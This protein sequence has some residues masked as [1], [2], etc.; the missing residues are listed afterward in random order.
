MGC[1]VQVAEAAAEDFSGSS[2]LAGQ[3]EAA[4]HAALCGHLQKILPVC[5]TRADVLWA[6]TRSWLELQLDSMLNHNQETGLTDGLR[7]GLDAAHAV[8]RS[9]PEQPVRIVMD[10]LANFWPPTRC[11]V[12]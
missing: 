3:F 8:K 11:V 10:D 9:N 7:A 2:E 6:Y 5:Q 1:V 4:L 12:A